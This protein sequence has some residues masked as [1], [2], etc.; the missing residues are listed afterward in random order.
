MVVFDGCNC[1]NNLDCGLQYINCVC[2][3][4]KLHLYCCPFSIFFYFSSKI[5]LYSTLFCLSY[6]YLKM[7]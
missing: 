3:Y 1:K 4:S 7:L 5:I 2:Y 6:L